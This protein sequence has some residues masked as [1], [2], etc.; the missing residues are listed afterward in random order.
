MTPLVE[1][2][3][4]ARLPRD[5]HHRP[6]PWFVVWM[7]ER[8][9]FTREARPG[10]PGAVP[11]FRVI[12]PGAIAGAWG[13]K[14]CWVCGMPFQRQ[15]PRAFTVG[16]MC[17]V[18]RISAEPPGHYECAVYS[19]KACPFLA[20]PHMTRRDRHLPEGTS[21]P[22][23]V[24][25]RRNP[26]AVAVWVTRYNQPSY[27]RDKLFDIG[28]PLFVEWYAQGRAATRAEILASI[29]SGLPLL[30]EPCQGDRAALA[31]LRDAHA[32]ALKLVPA[33]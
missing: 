22:P 32:E 10:E 33:R 2:P 12:K 4:I 8:D 19:A 26:G 7:A 17:S 9:G 25:L 18:N 6:V 21:D 30:A 23:G 11:D 15:E 24:F 3:R 29:E 5:K 13:R 20:T 14:L 28:A 27:R 16:P 1:P 31:A